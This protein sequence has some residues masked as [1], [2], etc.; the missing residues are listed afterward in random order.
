[1]KKTDETDS[2]SLRSTRTPSSGCDVYVCARFAR[3]LSLHKL[4]E[5]ISC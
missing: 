4:K 1:M 5:S 3:V 2:L